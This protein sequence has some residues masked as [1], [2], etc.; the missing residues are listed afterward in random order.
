MR[1]STLLD[2]MWKRRSLHR[3][4]RVNKVNNA[5]RTSLYAKMDR[6]VD[7]MRFGLKDLIADTLCLRRQ[8]K[9]VPDCPR[10]RWR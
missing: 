8:R 10:Q 5:M 7:K 9:T 4:K 6:K 3:I 2:R 1:A